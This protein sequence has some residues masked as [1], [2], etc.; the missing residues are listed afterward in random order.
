M[1]NLRQKYS[2][3]E[4]E[5]LEKGETNIQ[6]KKFSLPDISLDEEFCK[7]LI[8]R[9]W[10]ARM[11]GS[12]EHVNAGFYDGELSI[13]GELSFHPLYDGQT[14]SCTIEPDGTAELK[15]EDKYYDDQ[16]I[17]INPFSLVKFFKENGYECV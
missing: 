16:S 4:W 11:I 13:S 15:L 8:N 3:E 1:G 14:V 17:A 6:L 9:L 5:A 10:S 7:G 12:I 2:D